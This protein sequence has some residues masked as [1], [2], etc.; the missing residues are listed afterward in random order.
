M[1]GDLQLILAKGRERKLI[2]LIDNQSKLRMFT[3]LR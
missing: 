1:I 2:L 3:F